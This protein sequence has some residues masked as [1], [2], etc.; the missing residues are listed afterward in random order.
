MKALPVYRGRGAAENPPNRFEPIDIVLDGDAL[1]EE[2]AE[3]GE[4]LAPRTQ[5][6]RDTTRSINARNDSPDVSFDTSVNPYRGCE[7]GCVY[8]FARPFHEYLG[9]SAGLDFE[10]KILVKL[11][12]AELLRA[13]LASPRWTPQVIVMSGVTDPYQPIERKLR[14][15]RG[16][17]EVLAEA[18]NPVAIITKSFLVTRDIDL[19]TELASHGAAAVNMS[20]TSLRNDLQSIMEPRASIPAR[21]LAAVEQL[22]KAGVPVG[23]MVAPLIPGLTDE[24]MPAILQA[25]RDAGAQWAGYVTLRL[26]YAVKELFDAWL[27]RH[28]PE[29]R[30]KVLNRLREMRGGKLYDSRW[31]LR[32]RGEGEMAD[33]LGALF[34][35]ARRKAGFPEG[36]HAELSIAAFQRPSLTGQLGLFE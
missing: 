1:D 10:T 3:H 32:A 31:G 4:L 6:L 16:C 8:C 28:F 7:H 27:A 17:L 36:V 30:D 25:A 21:R 29:R 14:I 35:A 33:Q 12:A 5:L 23:I 18:R 9:F 19:Y 24:E 26:P 2:L 13:E 22:A 20:I 15:T 11:D 34:R